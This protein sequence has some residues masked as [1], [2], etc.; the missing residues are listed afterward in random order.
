VV[1]AVRYEPVSNVQFPAN[2]EINR[3]F[4]DIDAFGSD[5]GVKDPLCRSHFSAN[6]LRKL[7]GKFFSVTGKLPAGTGKICNAPETDH[8]RDCR[9]PQSI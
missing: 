6:S 9:I 7:T 5:F 1:C 4:C 2:R 8:R 3:E